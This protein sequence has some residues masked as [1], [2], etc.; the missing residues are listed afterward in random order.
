MRVVQ[1]QGQPARLGAWVGI[2]QLY[3]AIHACS[4]CSVHL[5]MFTTVTVIQLGSSVQFCRP[6]LRI[7][8][9]KVFKAYLTEMYADLQSILTYH[10]CT[11]VRGGLHDSD[12][13]STAPGSGYLKIHSWSHQEKPKNKKADD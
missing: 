6:F 5:R 7:A 2:K 12:S 4:V 1:Q 9:S 11:S 13:I 3:V 10:L 8:R